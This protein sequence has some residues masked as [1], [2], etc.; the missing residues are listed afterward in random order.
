MTRRPLPTRLVVA[1]LAALTGVVTVVVGVPAAALP[2]AALPAAALP[3]PAAA[4]RAVAAAPAAVRAT[5]LL[6]PVRPEPDGTAV[7]LDVDVFIPDAGGR[8]P[9]VLLAHGFGGS[10]SDLASRARELAGAGYVAVTWSARG[11]G[12]SSGRIHLDDPD[13]EVADAR[14]LVDLLAARPDVRLDG[15][16]DPRV[17]VAGGSY[18]GAL[19]LML[20]GADRRVDA[21][22]AL[23]TWHD[24]ADAF[25]P[26]SAVSAP[27]AARPGT[28]SDA[29]LPASPATPAALATP[30]AVDPVGGT[31]PLKQLWASRFFTGAVAAE[32]SRIAGATEALESSG[33]DQ[34]VPIPPDLLCGRFDPT[35]CRLFRA[36]AETGQPSPQLLSLLRRHSPAPLLRGIKVPTMLQQGMA[37]SLFGLDQADANARGLAGR[38]PLAVRWTDGGHDGPSSTEAADEQAA[39]TW[40]DAHLRPDT[41]PA[42]LPVPGFVYAADFATRG[43]AATLRS[44]PAY[45]GLPAYRGLAGTPALP[46]TTLPFAAPAREGLLPLLT[47]PAGQPASVTTVP[48]AGLLDTTGLPTYPLAALEGQ[49]AAFDTAAA[50]R[51]LTVVG[52]PRVRLRVLSSGSQ[53]TLFLSLWQ[54]GGGSANQPRRLVA[55]V[56]LALAPGRQ[57]ELTVALPPATYAVEP[58]T[59]WRL[60]V[61]STD[62][63]YAGPRQVRLDGVSLAAAGLDLPVADG[64]AVAD[65]GSGAAGTERDTQ[66]RVVGGL[67]AALLAGL[68][69][70]A[71]WRARQRTRRDTAPTAP[72]TA[73]DGGPPPPVVVEN[74]VKTYPDGHLAVDDI[75]FAVAPGEVVGLL[76]PNGAGKTTTIR[77]LLGLLRPD[78]GTVRVHGHPVEPGAPVLAH[79]GALVEGP[80]FLPH[81]SGRANLE[82]FWAATGRDPR[83]ARFEEVLEIAALGEAVERPVRTYSHGMRQRLGIAQSMLGVPDLLV[84]DEPTN[85]L[86]PPQIAAMRG[87]LRRYAGTGRTVLVSSHL[88]GEVEMTCTSVVV[89][90][91]GRVVAQGSVAELLE[92]DG[93]AV[94]DLATGAEAGALAEVLRSRDEVSAV[95]VE[96]G[97]R[98]VVHSSLPRAEVVRELVG[99]GA[100]VVGVSGRRHL[101][102]VFLGMI[103]AAGDDRVSMVEQ[104]AGMSEDEQA[105]AR[106]EHGTSR[107]EQA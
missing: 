105:R 104:G 48:G 5:T 55:P 47:P 66:S 103:A 80:G 32:G 50:P 31:G 1:V 23:I 8:H 58:G 45:P 82:A 96:G 64:A 93:T 43:R 91:Q 3:A 19:A 35:V 37:D 81:L 53:Q 73:A 9:A 41:P 11:F 74:L 70:S 24:L 28:A 92:A 13:Y 99:A 36:A 78:S 29:A 2:A 6:V 76:G 22:V 10:K 102:Q 79:V 56:R 75:S 83:D 54:V 89:L 72:L 33:S 60:L 38:V 84:L 25:F 87:V 51:R 59:V 68:L 106:D 16:G 88:L 69:V 4:A 90:H 20:A 101:E 21:V 57:Q 52:A 62:S 97:G 17:G 40:L 39:T 30:A 42:G 46:R 63:A 71:L 26:Q 49:S 98:L 94:V 86:D 14:A 15:A 100:P 27:A 107:D 61:T 44:L 34:P 95:D 7:R 67:L 77:V 65:G 85:G 18:G 12:R